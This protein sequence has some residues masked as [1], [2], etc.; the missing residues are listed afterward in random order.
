[1]QKLPNAYE[2]VENYL[3]M[4]MN[5]L[6]N[7]FETLNK[8]DVILLKYNKPKVKE[9]RGVSQG[10]QNVWGFNGDDDNTSS[11]KGSTTFMNTGFC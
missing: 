9:K 1:M 11:G 6:K 5:G 10:N 3:R 7:S 4:C 2:C 8:N